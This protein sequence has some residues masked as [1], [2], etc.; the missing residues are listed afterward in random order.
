MYIHTNTKHTFSRQDGFKNLWFS[1]NF[2]P[3][4][5]FPHWVNNDKPGGIK[6]LKSQLLK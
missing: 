4:S 6:Q 1:N 3:S 5:N 2:L